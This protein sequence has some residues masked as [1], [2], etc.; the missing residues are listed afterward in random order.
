V[1]DDQANLVAQ[2]LDG[3]T[4]FEKNLARNR[5]R[6][7]YDGQMPLWNKQFAATGDVACGYLLVA[8]VWGTFA[9]LVL[10]LATLLF[11]IRVKSVFLVTT[12]VL[13]Y[14]ISL[15]LLSISLIRWRRAIRVG[16][17]FRGQ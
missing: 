10:I 12:D 9:G 5:L 7:F 13:L 11:L 16:R 2:T 14:T 15:S 3:L 4:R 17:Q 1:D 8:Y 6:K